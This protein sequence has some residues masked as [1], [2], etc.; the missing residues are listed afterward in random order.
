MFAAKALTLLHALL[1]IYSK[2]RANTCH[3]TFGITFGI[4][5]DITLD[6]ECRLEYAAASISNTSKG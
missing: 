2:A 1:V 4:T 3:V 5:F 6:A